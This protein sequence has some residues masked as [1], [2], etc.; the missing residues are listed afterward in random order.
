MD[1]IKNCQRQFVENCVEKTE[2]YDLYR[3]PETGFSFSMAGEEREVEAEQMR[4][5][6][7][8]SVCR[9]CPRLWEAE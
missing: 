4:A 7:M 3:C 5:F 9:D 6:R 8:L 2:Q 1:G